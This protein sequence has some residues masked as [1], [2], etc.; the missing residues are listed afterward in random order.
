MTYEQVM[1]LD[2]WAIA[3][4]NGFWHDLPWLILFDLCFWIPAV[5]VY[6]KH[7]RPRHP[8]KGSA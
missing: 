7:W 8:K 3:Y 1:A 4:L 2:R 6:R 5:Y